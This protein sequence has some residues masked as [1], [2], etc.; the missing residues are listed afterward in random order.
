ML[1]YL[2]IVILF[3]GV[4]FLIDC[5]K[6]KALSNYGNYPNDIGQIM[7][8]QCATTG[9]HNSAS[10]LASAGLDLTTWESMFKGT[11]TGSSV[12]PF[13]SDFSSLCYFINTYSDLGPI[14]IPN[15]PL[16]KQHLNYKEVKRINDW[17][18][19]GAPDI[20]GN[21]KWA[22]NPLR[23]K[24]YVTNQ[25]CDVITVF[26]SET[27]LPMRYITVGR[28]SASI[29]VPHMV[30]VSP[31][32]QFWY[33]VFVNSNY[34]QK[35]RCSDDS[36][37]GEVNLNN[38]FDWNTIVISDDS[39]RAYCVSW[40]SSG[41]VISVDLDQMKVINFN[42]PYFFP[43]GVALNGTNDTLYVTGQTGNYIMKIDTSLATTQ[44]ISLN[45]L[46]FSTTSSLD[47]HDIL[48]SPDKQS[49]YITC[50]T[51]NEVRV[52][53]IASQ[54]VTNVINVGTYPVEMAI[55][56]SKNKLF[57][58]CMEDLTSFPGQHGS[59]SIID[60]TTFAEQRIQVG[61]MP[62][63]IGVDENKK[64]VYV[65]SRNLLT[66]GPPPHHSAVCAGR[67]GFV[68]FIDLNTLIVKPTRTE[69]S[70]DPYS[71]GVRK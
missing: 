71:V 41:V 8:L 47:P 44:T 30:K 69:I 18:N 31:D 23:K 9:C 10:A 59:V 28:N 11:S 32:G 49:F 68:S 70:V 39:K 46:P 67:N 16:N 43:H 48:L 62:H 61:F 4:L 24:I 56:T 64:L 3:F 22:D 66:T 35:Y 33:V 2:Y 21:V 20:N 12:I 7:V 37:V 58:T 1:R 65:A 63:G 52:F 15:M 40:V 45:G 53:S 57:V 38:F 36:F 51:S 55:S 13:R 60:M 25:G 26:D 34:M 17:I 29:E 6:D 50:Q 19:E 27:N 5:R 54:T 42:F 14:N